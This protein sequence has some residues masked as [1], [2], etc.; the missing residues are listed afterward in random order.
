MMES[1]GAL[2]ATCICAWWLQSLVRG[3]FVQAICRG[4]CWLLVLEN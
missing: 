3:G 4:T 2:D 1:V